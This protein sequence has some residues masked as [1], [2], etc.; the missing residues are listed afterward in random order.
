MTS[1]FN[2]HKSLL[3][4]SALQRSCILLFCG[5]AAT[6]SGL[7]AAQ[8]VDIATR[9]AARELAT[10]GAEAFERGDYAA[11][12]EQ[13][14]RANTLHPAP[15]ISILQ[16]RALVHLGRLIEALDRYEETVR[17]PLPE[18]A[19]EPYRVA[20][21]DAAAESENLK[22]R[23]PHLSVQVRRG[24]ATPKDITV[25]L[26]GKALPAVLL[27]VHFPADPGD[28]VVTVRAPK[29]DTVTRQ[30]HLAEQERVVLEITLD[31]YV[32]PPPVATRESQPD[33]PAPASSRPVWG[34]ATVG[35]GAAALLV[36]AITGK[37][38]L[39]KKSHLDSICNLP[40]CPKGS[41]GEIES[42]RSYRTASYLA[43]GVA[44]ALA[45]VGGYFLLSHSGETS[46]VGVGVI[47]TGAALWGAF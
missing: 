18:D 36:S 2:R 24:G 7:A 20:I 21:R 9:T 26:D 33:T 8:P 47:G 32:P 6:T 38:A 46:P 22:L 17:T 16:A 5:I 37:T 12:L 11:A 4:A 27:D 42:F 43:G 23:I 35:G 10:Q 29:Y 31:D 34:W 45:G 25:T 1:D 13:L 40:G 44:V 30:V 3:S 19:P 14:S 41:E 39:D 15:S 28:H